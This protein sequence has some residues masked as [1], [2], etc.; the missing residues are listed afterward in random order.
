[1]W[2]P[3]FLPPLQPDIPRRRRQGI[4]RL[5]MLHSR[6]GLKVPTAALLF[7]SLIRA[8]G[9]DFWDYFRPEKAHFVGSAACSG[10]QSVVVVKNPRVPFTENPWDFYEFSSLRTSVQTLCTP[11]TYTKQ[12]GELRHHVWKNAIYVIIFH[13]ANLPAAAA[14]RD[15]CHDIQIRIRIFSTAAILKISIR[16]YNCI[17]TIMVV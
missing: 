3:H 12:G 6:K 13:L 14:C 5:L 7:R 10:R 8:N 9:P 16:Y 17:L 4:R 15:A 1:M 2:V 11:K